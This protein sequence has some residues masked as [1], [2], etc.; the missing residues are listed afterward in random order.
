M[1]IIKAITEKIKEEIEDAN[2]YADLAL[3]WS[4]KEPEA[5][6]VFLELSKEEMGHAEKLHTI[7][8]EE[9]RKYREENGD[10]P[11]GRLAVYNYLHEQEIE[12]AMRVKIKQGMYK[13]KRETF[14]AGSGGFFDKE[15]DHLTV[16]FFY[17][18]QIANR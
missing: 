11:P 16:D 5:A 7:V 15:K 8:T 17:V 14:P 9:I 4:E 12:A 6:D 2:A 13:Q 1:M 3:E 18:H 10:P